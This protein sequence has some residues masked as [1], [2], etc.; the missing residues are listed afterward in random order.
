MPTQTR[1]P[2][3]RGAVM[4]SPDAMR[5]ILL[6]VALLLGG[7]SAAGIARLSIDP[8]A[9]PGAWTSAMDEKAMEAQAAIFNSQIARIE[10]IN[11]KTVEALQIQVAGIG[12]ELT[13]VREQLRRLQADNSAYYNQ[14]VGPGIRDI[15]LELKKENGR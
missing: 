11:D 3:F 15:L 14:I 10:G 7:G 4:I 1:E 8:D 12:A 2:E 5:N 9:R 13:G 6:T